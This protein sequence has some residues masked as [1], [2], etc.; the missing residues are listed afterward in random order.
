MSTPQVKN[1]FTIATITAN[2]QSN[3][4]SFLTAPRT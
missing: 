4:L 3:L 2:A 1:D